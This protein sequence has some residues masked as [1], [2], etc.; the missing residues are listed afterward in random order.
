MRVRDGREAQ[1]AIPHLAC[2][3]LTVAFRLH[4]AEFATAIAHH[5]AVAYAA[6]HHG[7]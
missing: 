6:L 5:A 4:Q 7:Y 1:V 3:Y 2:G